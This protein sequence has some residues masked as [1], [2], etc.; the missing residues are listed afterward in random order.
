MEGYA[1]FNED[2]IYYVTTRQ[3]INYVELANGKIVV[4]VDGVMLNGNRSK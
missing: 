4:F 3:L 1:G 2:S